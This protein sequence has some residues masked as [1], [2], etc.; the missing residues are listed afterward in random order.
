MTESGRNALVVKWCQT[1]QKKKF[2]VQA[3]AVI[4]NSDA[5]AWLAGGTEYVPFDCTVHGSGFE[6]MYILS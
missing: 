1:D 3:H 5:K 6:I 2:R 4:G